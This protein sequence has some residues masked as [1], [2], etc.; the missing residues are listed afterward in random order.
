MPALPEA[1]GVNVELSRGDFLRTGGAALV[2]SLAGCADLA[3]QTASGEPSA[4][5]ATLSVTY[6]GEADG[7]A[8]V[9]GRARVVSVRPS[10]R[11]RSDRS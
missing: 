1:R 2:A 7:S 9:D 10:N 3:S 6:V 8:A 11:A 4:P 5:A